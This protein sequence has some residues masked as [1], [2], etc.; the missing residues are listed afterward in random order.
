MNKQELLALRKK[1]IPQGVFNLNDCVVESAK[2]AIIKDMDGSEWIDF[3]GG[4]GVLNAG[5]CHDKVV[6][7]IKEQADKLIHSCFHVS[8]YEGY[9]KLADKLNQITPGNFQKKTMLANSGAEAVENAIKIARRFTGRPG[10]LCFDNA[11]HGRTHLGMSLTS[12]ISPY[13]KGF[14]P[15]LNDIYRIP[16]PDAYR[17]SGGDQARADKIALDALIKAFNDTFDPESIAAIIY[18]PIQGE[19]GFIHADTAF[20]HELRTLTQSYGILTIIDEVQSG[21]GRTGE[22]F[23][24]DYFDIDYD[25]IT[26]AKSIASGMPIS[27][28]TG[29]T[30]MMDASQVGGLGGTYGGNPLACAA[31]LATIEV[32]EEGLL[33]RGR[34]IGEKIYTE[35]KKFERQSP[36]IGNVRGV[37]AMV[38]FELVTDKTSKTPATEIAGKFFN[39]CRDHRLSMIGAGT[40]SNVV[41]VLV[42]FSVS[43]ETLEIGLTIIKKG[44]QSLEI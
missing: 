7:A 37:G 22:M 3:S 8:M 11:F 26:L 41:R 44:L 2:G 38:A 17:L 16:F 23:A 6:E 5:H 28:I 39:Y 43:N 20:Y 29:R 12:K 32:L 4:I 33:E 9:I 25:I 34:E 21:F 1:A 27:A 19:G 36:Y 42:P 31:A 15:L 30:E 14:G 24:A 40:H 18:E 13:K 35:F 10:I